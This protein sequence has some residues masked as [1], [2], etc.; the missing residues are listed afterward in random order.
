MSKGDGDAHTRELLGQRDSDERIYNIVEY[1]LVCDD[2]KK[3]GVVVGC[4]HGAH[5]VPPWNCELR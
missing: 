3:E 2:C 5:S 4:Q 1:S